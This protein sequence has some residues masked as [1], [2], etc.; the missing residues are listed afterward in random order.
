MYEMTGL[1][2]RRKLASA[3]LTSSSCARSAVSPSGLMN[4]LYSEV[5]ASLL[6]K[7]ELRHV[8]L[9]DTGAWKYRLRVTGSGKGA[10]E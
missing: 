4:R 5:R 2:L 8:H 1:P 6:R 10:Y 3:F 7:H 9:K